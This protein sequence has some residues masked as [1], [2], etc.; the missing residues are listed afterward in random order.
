[1]ILRRYEGR[2][3]EVLPGWKGETA[4]LL[5]G[6]PSLTL[7]QVAHVEAAHLIGKCRAA[8]VNDAY[9]VAPWA[10]L[11]YAA[12]SHWWRWQAEAR[13]KP[14]F[15]SARVREIFEAFA[16][17]R[18]SISNSGANI[19]DER[20]HLVKNAHGS[21]KGFG[22]SLDCRRVVTGWNSGFQAL[23]VA[24]LAGAKKIA[25]LGFDGAP[26]KDGRTHW[27]GGHPRPT[28]AAAFPL[29]AQ[30]M[31]HAERQLA[32]AGVR[33]V[34]CSPGSAIDAFPKM[35]IREVI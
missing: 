35:D 19:A 9:L 15:P 14:G 32:D 33:V 13:A 16:G 3:S 11:L 2:Y 12:D 27:H 6:G 34:N 10:D 22:L 30:A 29:Y 8:A 4:V 5:G 17:E 1:M 25:L 18:C 24:V 21:V 26:A 23:N 31:S 28:P 7:E 20:V